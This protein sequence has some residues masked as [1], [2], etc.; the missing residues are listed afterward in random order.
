MLKNGLFLVVLLVSGLLTTFN[1]LA[2]TAP[3]SPSD[4]EGG[5]PPMAQPGNTDTAADP[6]E[7]IK[8]K[9][10]LAPAVAPVAVPAPTAK[11]VENTPADTGYR[12]PTTFVP[13]EALETMR[14]QH[15]WMAYAFIWL[16]VFFFI[17]RTWQMNKRTTEELAQ[18]RAKLTALEAEDGDA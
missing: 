10:E 1:V 7:V 18:V 3:G 4:T 6:S 12:K 5:A 11:S 14:Y 13:S 16:F 15:L 8:P 2:Q 17:F 9:Q